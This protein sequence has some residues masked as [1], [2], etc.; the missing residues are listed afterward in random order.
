MRELK[1]RGE[2]EN[3][4]IMFLSDNGAKFTKTRFS[5]TMKLTINGSSEYDASRKQTP[6][7]DQIPFYNYYFKKLAVAFKL[8][9]FLIFPK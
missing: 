3:S 2:Y 8:F 7:I 6:K 4:I 1:K 9:K 5:T